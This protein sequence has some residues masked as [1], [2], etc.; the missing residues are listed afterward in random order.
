MGKS[1]TGPSDQTSSVQFYLP[2]FPPFGRLEVSSPLDGKS[3][4]RLGRILGAKCL[5]RFTRL[6]CVAPT[7]VRGENGGEER[8]LLSHLLFSF[9]SSCLS[10]FRQRFDK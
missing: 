2:F 3:G 8:F 4:D 6:I 10:F 7:K 9:G 5:R 1:A